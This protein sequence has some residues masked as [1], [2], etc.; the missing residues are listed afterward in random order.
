MPA[1]V[2]WSRRWMRQALPRRAG[3]V[4]CWY[5]GGNWHRVNAMARQVLH[6]TPAQSVDAEDMQESAVAYAS[7]IGAT[8][9]ETEA[10]ATLQ[11]V[12]SDPA[13]Q[14]GCYINGPHRSQAM[15]EAGVPRTVVLDHVYET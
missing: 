11:H 13:R 7:S 9:W 2:A 3:S 8:E 15:L 4:C 5:H 1:G 6:S 10:L 14:G 12:R